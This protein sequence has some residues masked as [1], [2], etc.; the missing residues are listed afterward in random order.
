MADFVKLCK[1]IIEKNGDICC[2]DV[3]DCGFSAEH[4]MRIHASGNER[5]VKN[6]KRSLADRGI[7]YKQYKYN[8]FA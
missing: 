2:Q 3:L 5:L 7:H 1:T 8:G 6:A 4:F